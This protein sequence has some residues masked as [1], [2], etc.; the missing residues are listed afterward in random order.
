[1]VNPGAVVDI[2]PGHGSQYKFT[3]LATCPVSVKLMGNVIFLN[4]N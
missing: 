4:L 3:D 2:C 1:M